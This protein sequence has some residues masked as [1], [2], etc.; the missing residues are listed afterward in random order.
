MYNT[1]KQ[2]FEVF[3]FYK[4]QR[5][6]SLFQALAAILLIEKKNHGLFRFKLIC[7]NTVHLKETFKQFYA[8]LSTRS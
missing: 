7:Y 5:L 4:R 2:K 6:F 1:S 3:D 8:S